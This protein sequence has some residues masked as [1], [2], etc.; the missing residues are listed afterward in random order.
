MDNTY[1]TI[2]ESSSRSSDGDAGGV[3]ADG[4]HEVDE[5]EAAVGHDAAAVG[6]HRRLHV[7]VP[8]VGAKQKLERS[9]DGWGK[10]NIDMFKG[11]FTLY[12][13]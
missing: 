3:A 2:K 7:R 9:A 11:S 1:D 13:A 6:A 8:L 4:V 12:N 5:L 10:Q